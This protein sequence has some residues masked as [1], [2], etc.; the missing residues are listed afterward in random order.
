MPIELQFFGSTCVID[1]SPGMVCAI[2]R[3]TGRA[4]LFRKGETDVGICEPC[5]GLAGW[6]WRQLAGE[7]SPGFNEEAASH[8]SR[9]YVLIARRKMVLKMDAPPGIPEAERKIPAPAEVDSSYEFL[10]SEQPDGSLDL[11][12][13]AVSHLSPVAAAMRALADVELISWDPLLE[14]LYTAYSPRGR[15]VEVVLARGWGERPSHAGEAMH[16]RPWPLSSHT[17]AMAG[18]W[19][20]LEPVWRLRLYKHCSV[21]EPGEL[22]VLLRKAAREFIELQEAVRRDPSADTTF[23]YALQACMSADEIAI[24]RMIQSA[25][26]RAADEKALAVRPPASPGSRKP[27]DKAKA[28]KRSDWPELAIAPSSTARETMEGTDPGEPGMEGDDSGDDPGAGDASE[29][30]PTFA[31][32][33]RSPQKE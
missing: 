23:M 18:F 33:P 17:G 13:A 1:S 31:R 10:L 5:S 9:V 28:G 8:V 25:A 21:G 15:L 11:P 27:H 2:C 14:P 12:S 20:S 26:K 29:E 4:F 22:C 16:W 19:R 32:P 3:S 24:A 30:D 6:A 7:V